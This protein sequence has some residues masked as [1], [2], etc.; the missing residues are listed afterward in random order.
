MSIPFNLV[1]G[2]LGSGKTTLLKRL[3]TGEALGD[4]VL[5]VNEFGEIGIDHLLV[6]EIA[7]DAVLLPSGCVCCSVRG[8]LKQALLEL[9]AKRARGEL[10]AFRRVLLE[11]TGLAEPAPILATVATDHQLRGRYRFGLIITV[12]D[13]QH[14][15]TQAALHPEWLA[16]V[17]AADRLLISKADVVDAD[18]IDQLRQRLSRL[19][20][21][22]VQALTTEIDDHDALLLD[23]GVHGPDPGGEVAQWRLFSPPKA[24]VHGEAQVCCLEFDRPLDWMLFGVWLSMLLRC[25]GQR[26]L[27]VKGILDV[28]GSASPV[29]IHGV[30]HCLHAP[31]HLAAWPKGERHSRLVFIVRGLEVAALRRSFTAFLGR[32]EHAL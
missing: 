7:P 15:V 11:T 10:P 23:A 20:P 5:L 28:A 18:A 25:H 27:R 30:Q 12:V 6:E 14:A 13:A 3:L 22:A 32:A 9:D 24:S 31:V 21:A 16:Q 1:T 2:F 17:A 29:V 26:I 4:T 8:D 19:N